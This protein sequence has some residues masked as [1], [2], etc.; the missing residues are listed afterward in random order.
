LFKKSHPIIHSILLSALYGQACPGKHRAPPIPDDKTLH[1]KQ[2]KASPRSGVGWFGGSCGQVGK[3]AVEDL[4]KREIFGLILKDEFRTR[5][6]G[7]FCRK[8][9]GSNKTRSIIL[10]AVRLELD[11]ITEKYDP[12][13][14]P[15]SAGRREN[16]SAS[17]PFIRFKLP[18][19]KIPR[20]EGGTFHRRW[21]LPVI[22]VIL[23]K[24]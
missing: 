8:A 6:R 10:T 23:P 24:S 1:A 15:R 9:V 2:R 17:P 13:P 3:L 14:S 11:Y 16:T 7:V 19:M 5:C 4:V 22:Y 20:A 21:Q 12:E 18:G